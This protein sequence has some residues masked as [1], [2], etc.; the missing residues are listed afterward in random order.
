M[1]TYYVDVIYNNE[2][3]VGGTSSFGEIDSS[4]H[5][6]KLCDLTAEVSRRHR[7][8]MVPTD[9]TVGIGVCPCR[10][11][12]TELPTLDRDRYQ[13]IREASLEDIFIAEL[14]VICIPSQWGTRKTARRRYTSRM[15]SYQLNEKVV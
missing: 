12:L 14:S 3:S 10:R 2:F 4:N 6:D 5:F 11:T 8:E 13:G 1:S 15:V 9:H 7:A